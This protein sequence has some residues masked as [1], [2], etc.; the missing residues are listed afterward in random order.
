MLWAWIVQ[1]VVIQID[2]LIL[3]FVHSD[4]EFAF[5]S[6]SVQ[7]QCCA[8][9]LHL[10]MSDS[11]SSKMATTNSSIECPWFGVMCQHFCSRSAV[12]YSPPGSINCSGHGSCDPLTGAFCI[13]DPDYV[14][15]QAGSCTTYLLPPQNPMDPALW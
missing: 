7:C 12:P 11:N 2:S 13:C 6:G 10:L 3:L 5:Y 9:G 15:S 14:N 4:L 8:G 1:V